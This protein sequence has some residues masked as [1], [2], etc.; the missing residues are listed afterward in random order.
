MKQ[1]MTKTSLLAGILL[2]AVS[3]QKKLDT[4][5]TPAASAT[6]PSTT[7]VA[8]DGFTYATS[9]TVN[10]TVSALTNSNKPMNG[11]PMN[12]YTLTADGQLGKL[13]FRGF[14][15]ASGVFSTTITVP[16]YCD[17]L[18]VDPAYVGLVRYA[19]VLLNSNSVSC[20]IG[21]SEGM[22]S[23]VV[24]TL[25]ANNAD[26]VVIRKTIDYQNQMANNHY[27]MDDINGIK[28]NTIFTPM[29]KYNGQGRPDYREVQGDDI[30]KE[31]LAAINASLPEQ[32]NVA[33]LH[34]DYVAA[35]TNSNIVIT[36]DADVWITFVYE[37]AGY[38]NTLGYYTYKTGSA[39]KTVADIKE[40]KYVFPNCSM[41]GSGGD[42]H[43]GDKVK[44]GTFPE[45]TTIGL[46]IF[47]NGWNGKD[48]NT[49][50]SNTYFS[51]A[52]LNPET[53][54]NLKKHNVLLQFKDTYIIG[55]EDMNRQNGGCDHDFND[56]LV[57]A[58]ANPVEAIST[59]NVQKADTPVDSDGD[60][61]SD[62]F[63]AY[64]KDP[65]R[66]YVNYYPAKDT[67]GTLAFED[68]WPYK[69]DYDLNDLVVKYNYMVVSNSKNQAVEMTANFLPVASGASFNNGFGV[70][71]G[72]PADYVKS[73][74][75][76]K[77]TQGYIKLNG[78]GVEAEQKNA[79]IIPFDA[80]QSLLRDGGGNF[81]MNTFM[82][83]PFFASNTI[84]MNLVFADG[85]TTNAGSSAS[86]VM[87]NF[88]PFLISNMKRG[89]E[90]HLPGF[91][92]TS[93]A[94]LTLLG[95]GN[96]ATNPSAGIFYVT[97]ENYPWA[98]NFTESFLYPTEGN[99]INNA[100]THFFEWAASGGA[101]YKDWYSNTGSGYR[102]SKL[103]YSK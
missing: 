87:G 30:S 38:M 34:P 21:G 90:V 7:K 75:G 28:T 55:F 39:P 20:T 14:T 60:G 37:G 41:P 67:W 73:A 5:A 63:D 92:P 23:N 69:G 83:Q 89:A 61:T 1:I 24:G 100:Y 12:L 49:A 29:G 35:G 48:I 66:A 11:V 97:R 77:H 70:D 80:A 27:R 10:V 4:T 74:D 22:S 16:G 81:T 13:V 33:K 17:T 65:T 2:L 62:T 6:T 15:N 94:D 91:K 43:S 42:L 84:T 88:N 50:Y 8:P 99:A 47:A 96:D 26:M 53:D 59:D 98:L 72:I 3:C 44:L 76:Q 71:L 82:E 46:V 95:Q 79:V 102:N 31:M 18:V 52:Y 68:L 56:V 103:I 58:T 86:L 78:N 19:K 93:L 32:T 36:K 64:P 101:S 85:V 40:I 25:Q 51:D 9:K 57:Y 45:G 54:A